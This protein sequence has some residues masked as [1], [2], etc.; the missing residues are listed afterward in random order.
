[1]KKN[2]FWKNYERESDSIVKEFKQHLIEVKDLD[3][4]EEH[5]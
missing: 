5:A 3:S 2:S 4:Y 1:M